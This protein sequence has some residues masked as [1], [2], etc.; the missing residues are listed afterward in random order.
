MATLTPNE[1]AEFTAKLSKISRHIRAALRLHETACGGVRAD[2][3][4]AIIELATLNE[5]FDTVR[6]REGRS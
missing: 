3:L 1:L 6:S 2:L 4:D 5:D